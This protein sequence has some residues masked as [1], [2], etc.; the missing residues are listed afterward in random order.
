M[1]TLLKTRI[2]LITIIALI[3]LN[4]GSI[5]T[6]WW[7]MDNRKNAPDFRSGGMGMGIGRGQGMGRGI[8]MVLKNRLNFSDD[9]MM[10]F[11]ELKAV[12]A[13]K[14]N[15]L[16]EMI[17]DQKLKLNQLVSDEKV[18][19]VKLYS[20]VESIASLQGEMEKLNFS[21]FRDIMK[22]CNEEQKP[23]FGKFIS[24]ELF[25]RMRRPFDRPMRGM[26]DHKGPPM[27]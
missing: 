16:A 14:S 18:D 7:M 24:E 11:E 12:H 20:A 27:E 2:L 5:V 22:I 8:E 17:R 4:V 21:H 1:E 23:I 19:S 10:A 9:Q 13:Q 15:N 3:V 6:I 26:N 25:N